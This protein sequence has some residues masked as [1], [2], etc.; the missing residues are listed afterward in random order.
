M[1]ALAIP[2]KSKWPR[3]LRSSTMSAA[4]PAMFT[5]EVESG[6]PQVPKR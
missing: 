6:I 2:A 4:V 3:R 1:N 5:I